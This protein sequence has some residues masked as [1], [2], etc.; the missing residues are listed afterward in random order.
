VVDQAA[1]V[2][3]LQTALDTERLCGQ[4]P[5]EIVEVAHE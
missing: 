4:A 2:L 1:A 3:I 5:G